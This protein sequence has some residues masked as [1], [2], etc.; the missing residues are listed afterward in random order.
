MSDIVIAAVNARYSH[1]SLAA[2]CLRANLGPLASRARILE[3]TLADRPADMLERILAER[4]R[5]L[6]LGVYVWNAGPAADL[7]ARMKA[8]RPDV[9]VILGGPEVSHEAGAQPIVAL[10]DHVIQGEGEIAFAAL[11]ERLLRGERPAERVIEASPPD[12][13]GLALPYDLYDTE[14]LAHRNVYV[15]ASRGCPYGCEFCLSAL[16]RKV[17]RFPGE[18]VLAALEALWARGARRFKFV[19]RALH[20]AV[21]PEILRFFL[22]RCEPGAHVHF[23]LV[24]DRL[25]EALRPLVAA[26]P[27]G[28]LQLEAGIQTLDPEVAARVGRRQDPEAA[29]A[30]VRFL[31]S[32]TNA[33]VHADL[34]AGL[35]GETLL[36]LAA[37][38]DRLFDAG[39][40][41]IQL[42]ILKRLRG[43]PIARHDGPFGMVYAPSAPYE[44]M[45]TSTIPF[46]DMQR[47]K[48]TA[49]YLDL[50]HNGGGF[51]SCDA[52]VRDQGPPF[53]R[54]L[55]LADFLWK[56][57]RETHAP[58]QKLLA[59]GLGL[60][61]EEARGLDPSL[62]RAAVDRDLARAR[63]PRE[64]RYPRRQGRRL[65]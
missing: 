14:D 6:G 30:T 64:A 8:L 36:S 56:E 47:V 65:A 4:P 28:A 17:R 1:A 21:T 59:R 42:G 63:I 49:R 62:V 15:E 19:D 35:P 41:E 60:Y 48:R 32:G 33:H 3:F 39:P 27:P 9:A 50:V 22:D 44:I 53:A 54:Y 31:A 40:H 13:D 46:F 25:P 5:L 16:D 24:P 23:E 52:L 61:L 10:A 55:E 45:E 34:V 51:P 29:L 11:C 58:S 12:L 18:R 26:F 20:L 37:G 2:R 7:V 43:A 57:T 38:F